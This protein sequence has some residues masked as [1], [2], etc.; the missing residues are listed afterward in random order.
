MTRIPPT[1]PTIYPIADHDALA[2]EVVPAV[3]GLAEAGA[4]WIQVRAKKVGERLRYELVRDA[5]R[6][7][8]RHGAA[9][10]VDD[11]VDLAALLPVA[12]VHLGQDDLPPRAARAVVG[13]RVW[14]G[15]ST[16]DEEQLR[17]AA[18]DDDVD[19]V[20]IGPVFPTSSKAEPDPVVGLELVRRARRWTTKPLVAIGGIGLDNVRGVL[21][22]GADSAAA[23][24][25]VC[26]AGAAPGARLRALCE[27]A[28]E[29]R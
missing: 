1:P 6:V 12:G 14:I 27:A 20:A 9:I 10:W 23:I 16:H 11:R 17:R 22:A 7:A 29:E 28:R 15:A 2:G 4:G 19:V 25:A 18:A 3:A 26:R 5:C 24:G 8:A 13:P 21:D